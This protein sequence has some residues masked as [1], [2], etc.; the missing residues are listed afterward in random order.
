MTNHPKLSSSEILATFEKAF[1]QG[2]VLTKDQTAIS[3]L[4][5]FRNFVEAFGWMT[6]VGMWAEKWNHHPEWK[7]VYRS[8]EVTL[9]THD[10]GG[11]SILDAKLAAKMDDLA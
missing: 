10:A 4:Y 2:W 1:S 11:L 9:T 6:K 3:K 8:V 7:N 5:E